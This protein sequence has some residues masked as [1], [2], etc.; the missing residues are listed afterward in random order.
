MFGGITGGFLWPSQ[1]AYYWYF[2][3]K[4]AVAAT[5]YAVDSQNKLSSLFS[6]IFL[7]CEI[8][9]KALATVYLVYNTSERN[10]ILLFALCALLANTGCFCMLCLSPIDTTESVMLGGVNMDLINILSALR[11][12]SKDH[13]LLSLLPFQFAFGFASSYIPFYLFGNIV[14]TSPSLGTAV[15]GVLS[16]LVVTLGAIVSIL[17]IHLTSHTSEVMVMIFSGLGLSISGL[18]LVFNSDTAMGTQEII[19]P[20]LML[21]GTSRGAWEYMNRAILTKHFEGSAGNASGGFSLVTFVNGMSA[22][23]G[24]FAFLLVQPHIIERFIF[25]SA[26]FAIFCY[27]LGSWCCVPLTSARKRKGVT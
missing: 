16:S 26:T 14:A 11:L 21:Y 13:Y 4:Y 8:L 12:I 10:R 19:I 15:I 24:Y 5:T 3:K 20:Y 1:A 6:S 18:I 25:W 2:T 22:A 17:L 27:L 7:S 9:L 23:L